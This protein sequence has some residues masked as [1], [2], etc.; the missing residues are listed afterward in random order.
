M[1]IDAT[2]KHSANAD[3]PHDSELESTHCF[4]PF[5]SHSPFIKVG[6]PKVHRLHPLQCCGAGRFT[7]VVGIGDFVKYE[8]CC[9]CLLVLLSAF[10]ALQ[11][12]LQRGRP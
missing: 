5:S 9:K 12:F 10:V 6:K 11:V 2:E 7:R 8:E 3:T 1:P 4:N